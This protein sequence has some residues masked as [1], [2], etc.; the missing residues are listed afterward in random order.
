MHKPLLKATRETSLLFSRVIVA[1]GITCSVLKS[2]YIEDNV[3][4]DS[5]STGSDAL[6]YY[7]QGLIL[8]LRSLRA[9]LGTTFCSTTEDLIMKPLTIIDLIEYYVHLAYA[10]HHR[11]SKVLLLLVQPLLITFTNGH[12]PYEVDMKKLLT[13]IPEVAVQNNVGLQVS[14]ERN[15]PH[16]VPED[17]RWQIISVCLWQ[18]M[19]RF[20]QHNLNVLSYNLDD[21][22]CFVGEPHR[23]YFSWAPS[24]A[25]LDSD[26]SS[27]KEL[28]GL[29]SLSLVKLLKPTLSQVASYHVKQLA[30]LLQHKMDN[31][32]RVTTLVWLEESNKSQPGALNQH[33]NQDNV[34]LD[35]IGERLEAVMLWDA[36][37]DPKII[38]ESF[39]LEKIDLSHSLDHKP[40]NGWGTINRGIGA[41]DK[42]E[43][44]HNHEVTLN[45]SSPNSEA[46]SP[47]K[48]V[49]RGGHYFLSAWQ[50]DTTITKEV[51]SFLNPKEI[52]KRNGELLEVHISSFLPSI[53]FG[54]LQILY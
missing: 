41:A 50:K 33:L 31:G 51:T 7:F 17:E 53:T 38:S 12:T 54:N 26:G 23:K 34:K 1:C 35:M 21:D 48:S 2:P 24:S 13:Q 43:E 49:F 19:S 6:E 18:H 29:V 52:Y 30:S 10:W 45:S 47:A 25:S 44:I 4:G 27:L 28:I 3:S 11:N 40:S 15:I 9:A 36:C 14:Q 37:A 22:G 8:L 46:G 32:L 16:L 5:R 20:M 39:A 42:T